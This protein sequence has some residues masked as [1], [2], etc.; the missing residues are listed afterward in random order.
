VPLVLLMTEQSSANCA[1]C[2]AAPDI[3]LLI[4]SYRRHS[5]RTASTAPV[6]TGAAVAAA[7][8]SGADSP[9]EPG[10][11]S[12]PGAGAPRSGGGASTP[13]TGGSGQRTGGPA[14]S[15]P[16]SGASP[17]SATGGSR[18]GGAGTGG[19]GGASTGRSAR[20]ITPEQ[21]AA[22]RAGVSA[23]TAQVA[24]AQQN[25]AAA[26]IQSPIAGTVAAVGRVRH[27]PRRRQDPP[28][29]RP[30]R[31]R[32]HR[33]HPDHRGHHRRNH[34]RAR[35]PRRARPGQL[36]DPPV[37]RPCRLR[38]PPQ[39]GLHHPQ[40]RDHGEMVEV[41]VAVQQRPPLADA[42]RRN[43][44]V[45]GTPDRQPVP[46]RGA[47]ELRGVPEVVAA[48]ANSTVISGQCVWRR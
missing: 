46:P 45:G 47:I 29:P 39:L 9:A 38:R 36:H 19:G 4:G 12:E 32:R 28:H 40:R 30:G 23:A 11:P 5:V 13:G 8:R 7:P 10:T 42:D 25:L 31:R 35:R 16:R 20:P 26:T 17:G 21:I 3:P 44:T 27:R 48:S 1:R 34:G 18:T 15:G 41:R 22:D 24:V 33:L 37:R 43:E 14:G 6:P 2:V